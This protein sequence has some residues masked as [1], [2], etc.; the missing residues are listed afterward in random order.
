MMNALTF[1]LEEY[2]HAEAFAGIVGPDDWPHLPSRV[3]ESTR[4]LLDM[5][6]R[7][8]VSATSRTLMPATAAPV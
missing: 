7:H 6:D 5:L 8:G 4:R 2:F 1:D 3:V